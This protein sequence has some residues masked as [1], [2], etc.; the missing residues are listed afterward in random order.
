MEN[1]MQSSPDLS[2]LKRY[3]REFLDVKSDEVQ[4]AKTSRRYYH[5]NQTSERILKELKKRKQPNITSNFIRQ[6]I[7][8]IVGLDTRY[9]QDPKAYPRTPKHTGQSDV[10]T[11]AI[12]FVC[13]NNDWSGLVSDCIMDATQSGIMVDEYKLTQKEDGQVEIVIDRLEPEKFFYDPKSIKHDFS[14]ATY[15]GS[16]GW[17]DVDTAIEMFPDK[18][19]EIN[20]GIGYALESVSEDPQEDW[21]NRWFDTNRKL[22]KIVEI[23]TK[24]NGN[25]T[26]CFIAGNSKL[27]SG[28]SPFLDDEGNSGCRFVAQSAYIDEQGDRYSLIRDLRP[29]QDEINQR[30]S[31][32]LHQINTRQTWARSGVFK[33]VNDARLQMSRPDGHLEVEGVFG[34]D[35]GIID[36]NDQIAGQAKLLEASKQEMESFGPGQALLGQ[37][38]LQDSSGR[39]LALHLQAGMAK[40]QPFFNR[41]RSWKLRNY[42]M[43]WHNV[44]KYWDGE[45]YIMITDDPADIQHIPVNSF[46]LDEYGRPMP[47]NQLTDIDVDIII[48]EAPDTIT[49]QSEAFDKM[50]KLAPL[51]GNVAPDIW[52]EMSDLDEKT[53]QRVK[54]RL[55]AQQ[56]QDP[57]A[58]QAAQLEM[59]DKMAG[60]E[61]Q[62]VDTQKAAAATEKLQAETM[63]ILHEPLY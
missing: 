29:L 25:W 26:Y 7:D 39:A 34:Q 56:Q 21:S 11:A 47:V 37:G 55:E 3:F 48:D 27:K 44:R 59:A 13:D 35:W 60:I 4:E 19:Q 6:T 32:M 41:V 30:R 53:K 42:R 33:S 17:F 50:V 20:E 49:L 45:R 24:K 54:K 62:K 1:M 8:G 38:G 9:R 5:G 22:V 15:M 40:M 51:M 58:A 46:E 23:W 36:Q 10:A 14:D 31:K 52:V 12:R 18:E 57:M 16:W 43:I 61:Q 28:P 2:T 63:K